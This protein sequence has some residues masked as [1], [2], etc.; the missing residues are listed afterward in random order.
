MCFNENNK[1]IFFVSLISVFLSCGAGVSDKTEELGNG[2][3]FLGEGKNMN[4]IYFGMKSEYGYIIDSILIYPQ[5]CDY[6][7]NDKFILVKQNPSIDGYVTYLSNYIE[8]IFSTYKHI[9]STFIDL[10]K[11]YQ[12]IL[13]EIKKD[14][15]LYNICNSKITI[16]NSYDDQEICKYVAKILIVKNKKISDCFINNT[17]YW[18]IDKT[19]NVVLGPFSRNKFLKKT[20]ECKINL[21]L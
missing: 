13:L 16:Y 9:D 11:K 1:I 4:I 14:T 20:K 21:R 17:N 5:V 7:Y 3:V 18:I 12:W 2:Y 8:S 10:P 19:R 6:V 15:S